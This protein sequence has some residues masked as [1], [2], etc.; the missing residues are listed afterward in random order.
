MEEFQE[1]DILW[2]DEDPERDRTEFDA[3]LAR[4]RTRLRS[5]F[6]ISIPNSRDRVSLSWTVGLN[7]DHDDTDNTD[8]DDQDGISIGIGRSIIPPHILVS[9]R[10]F[11][12]MQAGSV[13]VGKGRKLK[14]RDLKVVRTEILRM[15]GYIEK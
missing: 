11:G 10:Y 5:S 3:Q 14:G 12:E 6:P 15:T 7:Y 1:V 13:F 9:R 4:T 8:D 2:P